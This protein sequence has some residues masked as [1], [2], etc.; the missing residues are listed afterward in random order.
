M[1]KDFIETER[2][3]RK[4]RLAHSILSISRLVTSYY[5]D[6]EFGGY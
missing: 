5:N 3:G 2:Q 1:K 6:L 4:P